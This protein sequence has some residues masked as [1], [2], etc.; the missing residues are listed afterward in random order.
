MSINKQ[1]KFPHIIKNARE[2]IKSICIP[3][4]TCVHY[5]VSHYKKHHRFEHYFSVSIN[6]LIILRHESRLTTSC[7]D[8][9]LRSDTAIIELT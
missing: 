6:M 8:T 3:T 9:F 5:S 2:S 1:K 7:L 4:L